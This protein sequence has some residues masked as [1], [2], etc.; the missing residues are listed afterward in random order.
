MK[1]YAMFLKDLS[2]VNGVVFK[3]NHNY[4]ILDED[5][6]YLYVQMKPKTNQVSQIPKE[7]EGELFTISKTEI[8]TSQ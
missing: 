5:Q 3:K 1:D 4:E 8:W 7:L 6:E 2:D